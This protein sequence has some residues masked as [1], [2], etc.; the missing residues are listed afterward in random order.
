MS[1]SSSR[2]EIARLG[3][4]FHLSISIPNYIA[5]QTLPAARLRMIGSLADHAKNIKDA[6]I[7]LNK[8]V[9]DFSSIF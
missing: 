4:S 7:D 2:C 9:A 6:S 8:N 1:S 3:V 5:C